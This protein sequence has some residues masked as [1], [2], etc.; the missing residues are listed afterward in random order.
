VN[1]LKMFRYASTR[2]GSVVGP[3]IQATGRS[4]FEDG[5]G[6]SDFV[7]GYSY[8]MSVCTGLP[9]LASGVVSHREELIQCISLHTHCG[10]LAE[11]TYGMSA[12]RAMTNPFSC[13]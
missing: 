6:S 5:W 9:D 11:R 12:P 13:Q 4:E 7:S 2:R 10:V 1:N 3:V 8:H